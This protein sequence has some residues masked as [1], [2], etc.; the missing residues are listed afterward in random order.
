[1][2]EL[3]KEQKKANGGSATKSPGL[4]SQLDKMDIS[5]TPPKRALF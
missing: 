2:R 5:G 1:M 3:L 4:K